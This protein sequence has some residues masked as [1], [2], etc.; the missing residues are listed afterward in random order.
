MSR[1]V[2]LGATG[3]LGK[4]VIRQAV[5]AGHE[6]SA[7]VRTPSK[8]PAELRDRVAII[9]LD[10]STATVSELSAALC[11]HDV[12]INTAG[13][14]TEGETFVSLVDRLVASLESIPAGKRP[15]C[16]FMAGAGLL[17]IDEMGRRGV[18]LPKIN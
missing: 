11:D 2:V 12:L 3:S 17:D 1:I 14:V 9:K 6:V 16:W 10:L 5:A 15:V 18:D 4:H 8:I 7:L 13:L